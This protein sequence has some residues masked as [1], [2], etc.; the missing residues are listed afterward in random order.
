MAKDGEPKKEE[1]LQIVYYQ[2]NRTELD[3]RKVGGLFRE[4]ATGNFDPSF[5]QMIWG[6]RF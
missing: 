6:A 4:L 2:A 1:S 3:S 5:V